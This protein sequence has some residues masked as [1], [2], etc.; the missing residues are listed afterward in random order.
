M[1]VSGSVF[2][3]DPALPADAQALRIETAGF[4]SGA[5]VYL[6]GALQG[7]LNFAGVY[8]LPLYKGRHTVIVEDENGAA[9]S[10]EFEV[11]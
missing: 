10:V 9:A 4:S 8:A 2:Y 6:N 7:G 5:Y 3:A 1:P 11:R